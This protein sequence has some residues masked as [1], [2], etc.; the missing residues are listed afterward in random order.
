MQDKQNTQ[1]RIAPTRG[2]NED[3]L[4]QYN[5]IKPITKGLLWFTLRAAAKMMKFVAKAAFQIPGL[6]KKMASSDAAGTKSHRN[7]PTQNL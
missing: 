6:V 1:S 4:R 3:R 2:L 5:D 7:T